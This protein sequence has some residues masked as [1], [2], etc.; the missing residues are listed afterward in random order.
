MR[1]WSTTCSSQHL[2]S[3]GEWIAEGGRGH[4][5]W[6]GGGDTRV[7]LIGHVD[8][9]WPFGTTARWP[10]DVVDGRASGPGAFD[11]KAGLVQGIHALRELDDLTGVRGAG[12]HRRGGRLADVAG[13]H[14]ADRRRAHGRRW[15]SSRP[16]PAR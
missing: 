2:G 15:C 11:M 1:G 16:P 8:T 5:L 14:R 3:R 4:L 13:A 10:F 7:V 12:H 9:V 6:S